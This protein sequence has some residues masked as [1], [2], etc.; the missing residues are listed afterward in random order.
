[1]EKRE[2][3]HGRPKSFERC[4]HSPTCFTCP[5]GDCIAEQAYRYNA[6]DVDRDIF[7]A[8]GGARA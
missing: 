4:P 7:R 6:L 2:G 8:L 5:W 1:M 3:H